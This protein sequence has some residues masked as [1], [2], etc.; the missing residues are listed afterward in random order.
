MLEFA[1]VPHSRI[2]YYFG[3]EAP[4]QVPAGRWLGRGAE[5]LGLSGRA[6][7]H[8]ALVSLLQGVDPL[9]GAVLDPQHARVRIAAFDCMVSTPKSISLLH[10][11]GDAATSERVRR[12]H[13]AS[14]DATLDYLERHAAGVRRGHAG[15]R[16]QPA[17]GLIAA[18]FGHETSRA[19]D[20][21]LH[22]HVLVA[23]LVSDRAGRWSGL[24][25]MRLYASCSVAD[26]L[27]LCQLRYELSQRLDVAFRRRPYGGL[28]LVG[29]SDGV[30]TAFS[31]RHQQIEAEQARARP[32]PRAGRIA[33]AAT[34]P[35][36]DASL[37]A[38]VRREQWWER[39]YRLG[40]SESRLVAIA[41]RDTVPGDR[42][43]TAS[44]SEETIREVI[45]AMPDAFT[46][47]D[48]LRAA[49]LALV[50]GA[51]VAEVERGVEE[52]LA[53]VA[54]RDP[55]HPLVTA[56]TRPRDGRRIPVGVPEPLYV[57]ADRGTPGQGADGEA[58]AHQIGRSARSKR[59]VSMDGPPGGRD[60]R[61]G[62]EHTLGS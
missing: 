18:A 28:D 10:A 30:L 15:R 53:V 46:R 42:S 34:R 1:R 5:A 54:V 19:N 52:A 60:G 40:V 31:Q 3:P 47:G 25:A 39:A 55:D 27:Y 57:A 35:P 23:N 38:G 33:A 37:D 56:G 22:S 6:V 51:P 11:L 24:H 29:L 58:R 36:K 50:D 59:V 62:A 17:Q 45:A 2:G 49:A 16:R 26:A 48:A 20:P 13:D 44:S 7:E 9:T 12:A 8:P 43:R 21:H 4:G 14:I 41:P 32:G 61:R